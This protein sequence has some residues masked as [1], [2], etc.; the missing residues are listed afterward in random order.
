[1]AADDAELEA[2]LDVHDE[3]AVLEA[4]LDVHN[5]DF[6][7]PIMDIHNF[8]TMVT[9]FEKMDKVIM[10][11][12]IRIRLCDETKLVIQAIETMQLVVAVNHFRV[13]YMADKD[14]ASRQFLIESNEM[15]QQAVAEYSMFKLNNG[16]LV[17]SMIRRFHEPKPGSNHPINLDGPTPKKAKTADGALQ[18]FLTDAIETNSAVEAP[19]AIET[20]SPVEAPDAIID[21]DG[22]TAGVEGTESEADDPEEPTLPD[23]LVEYDS[24]VNFSMF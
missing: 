14:P 19:D 2:L 5:G 1:M 20:N 17:D 15:Y 12:L 6:V 11:W 8:A 24:Q 4:L 3:N 13:G 16:D 22:E 21:V 9:E 18:D 10:G 23:S 7:R